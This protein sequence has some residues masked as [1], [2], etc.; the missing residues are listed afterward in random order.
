MRRAFELAAEHRTHPNPR[1][2]AVVVDGSGRVIGEGAHAGAGRSHAEIVALEK[3]G[4]ATAGS[5]L[6]V[7][8]EPCV[9][10]GQTPPCVDAIVRAG[11]SRVVIGQI[12][13]DPRVSGSGV[14]RLRD[15][16]LDVDSGLLADEA[17]RLDPGY[18]RHRRT[19]LPRVVLKLAMTLD[20]SI[21]A[22]DGTSQWLT[23]EDSRIDAHRLRADMDG[24]V[25]GAGTVREDDPVL[26]V[27][28]GDDRHQPRP[29]VIAGKGDL[30]LA[31]RIWERVPIVV[32]GRPM[33]LPGGELLVVEQRDG[34]PD[35]EA[36]ARALGA[37]GLYDLVLEGG[38]VLAGSWWRAGVVS[39]GVVYMAGKVAGGAGVGPLAGRFATL[40]EARPVTFTD[41]RRVGPDLRIE[42]E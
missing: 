37:L 15:A 40:S 11:V 36:A 27:R 31:A 1:V 6:F 18:F 12:D 33:T 34:Y 9:H 25:V 39:S 14:E 23:S 30:P 10:H 8:L 22:A 13:P 16:G 35:P 42:F 4:D 41:V 21:A 24:V 5:T 26:T 32:A 19:G 29:V 17:E 20:G 28:H 2:G 3:A 7:N 38:A